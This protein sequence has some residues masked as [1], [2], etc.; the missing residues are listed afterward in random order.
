MVGATL[1]RSLYI[2]AVDTT[3][4]QDR[5]LIAEFNSAPNKNHFNGFTWNCADFTRHVINTYFPRATNSDYINDFGMT[6]PKAIARSFTRFALRHPE[7]NFRVLHFAQVPGTIKRSSECRNGTEQL[8]H[9]KK[10]LIPM[11][12]FADHVLPV[13]AASY[14]LTGR[15]NPQHESEKYPA[16]EV[17]EIRQRIQLAKAAKNNARARQLRMAEDQERARVVGT[18]QEWKE[19]REAFNVITEEAVRGEIIP[20][21]KELKRLFKHMDGAGTPSVDGNGAVWMEVPV[22]D[23]MSRVGLSESNVL[24]QVSDSRLAYRL[25]LARIN[26]VLR[27]PKH[28]RET[29]L[30]FKKDWTLMQSARLQNDVSLTRA[31]KP[32]TVPSS[33]AVPAQGED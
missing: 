33:A 26:S 8:Y 12:L 3:V 5:E 27:S 14:L 4:E 18:S 31:V 6:S 28:S 7:A 1:I 9:S 30:E 21:R 10:F 2:F 11:L 16:A 25:L 32:E 24:A 23:G 22:G 20:D 15:F 19:Y 29:M 13:A 17:T